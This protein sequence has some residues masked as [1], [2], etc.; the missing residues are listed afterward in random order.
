M[1]SLGSLS[2]GLQAP[3]IEPGFLGDG[4]RTQSYCERGGVLGLSFWYTSDL[5]CPLLM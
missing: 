2:P 1:A 5:S 3:E 4:T